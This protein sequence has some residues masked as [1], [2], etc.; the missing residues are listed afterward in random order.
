MKETYPNLDALAQGLERR[1]G[2]DVVVDVSGMGQLFGAG[3]LTP[4]AA[5]YPFHEITRDFRVM[6]AFHMA[7]SV[8]AGKGAAPEGVS[9]Q[10]LVR[11][12]GPIVGGDGPDARGPSS[13][14]TRART[15]RGPS[16]SERR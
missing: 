2:K 15:R 6:T 5:E 3:E 10:D 11:D 1:A 14:S 4:I 16:P 9:A 8:Q 13:C 7:R 12:L